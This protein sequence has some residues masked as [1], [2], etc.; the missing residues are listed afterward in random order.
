VLVAAD[1][2]H[3]RLPLVASFRTAR[4]TTA[5]KDALLVRVETDDGRF[6][7]G[8]CIAQVDRSYLP[9]NIDDC[10]TA[11]RSHLIPAAL[12][13]TDPADTSVAYAAL[14]CAM[15]DAE[16]RR[17][18]TALATHLGATREFVT[19]GVAVGR[20]DHVEEFTRAIEAYVA[21][22]YTRIKCKIQPGRDLGPLRLVRRIAPEVEL[23]ADANG[24]YS[25]AAAQKLLD[26]VAAL[27]LQCVEQP[28][29]EMV[30]LSASTPVCLDESIA[31]PDDVV[32]A[33]AADA[34]DA[35]SIKPGRLGGFGP[36]QAALDLCATAGIDALPG[37][38]LETGIGRAALLAVASMPGFTM[39]GDISASERYFGPDGDLTEPFVLEDGRIRVPT[40]PGLGVE[41]IPERL[42]A[43]TI[44]HER[45][46]KKD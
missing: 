20:I 30:A 6:G 8:E 29:A 35:V 14:E 23:A 22:G 24:S 2:Y 25:P 12:A 40:G 39:T 45:I 38:M 10:R 1:L 5:V 11:L 37:G 17:S 3:V 44:A 42:A 26:S 36:T 21:A 15:L 32:R 9:V 33:R 46:T 27:S 31:A 34:C 18:N 43:C 28:C 16:L 41:P 19:A 7:W 13:G 4:S